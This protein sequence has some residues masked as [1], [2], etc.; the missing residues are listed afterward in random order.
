MRYIP[1]LVILVVPVGEKHGARLQIYPDMDALSIALADF[2]SAAAQV[3]SE[4][5]TAVPSGIGR[6]GESYMPHLADP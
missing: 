2:I 1:V 3:G 4:W 6:Q 5:R